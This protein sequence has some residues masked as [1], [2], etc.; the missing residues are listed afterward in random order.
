MN[1][2][3]LQTVTAGWWG[4]KP[5]Q[6]LLARC[7]YEYAPRFKVIDKKH[8]GRVPVRIGG[9]IKGSTLQY[10]MYG[11]RLRTE[12]CRVTALQMK[13]ADETIMRYVRKLDNGKLIRRLSTNIAVCVKGNETRMGKGKGEF[14]HWMCRV[15]TGKIVFEMK[16]DN[17]HERVAREAFRKAGTKLP[18]SYE[19]VTP[20]SLARCGLHTFVDPSTQIDVPISSKT[21]KRLDNRERAKLPE[22]YLYRGR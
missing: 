2:H 7:K 1:Q 16:G 5:W 12:G 20:Q 17:L 14:D 13:A 4:V 9:S 18:G 21:K 15:P 8:K 3:G 10:G 19:F 11:M 6:L 22:Y